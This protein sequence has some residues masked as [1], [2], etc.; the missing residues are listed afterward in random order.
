[1]ASCWASARAAEQITSGISDIA[2]LGTGASDTVMPQNGN[3]FH[4]FLVIS[5]QLS[6]FRWG[7]GAN[8]FPVTSYQFSE[9]AVALSKTGGRGAGLFLKTGNWKLE[10]GN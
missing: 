6:V 9:G 5:Y 3:G 10:T 8:E 2:A 1:L 7:H 4:H